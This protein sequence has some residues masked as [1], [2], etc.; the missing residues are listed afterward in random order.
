MPSNYVCKTC[1]EEFSRVQGLKTHER[2]ERDSSEDTDLHA[3]STNSSEAVKNRGPDSPRATH[4]HIS[5][6]DRDTQSLYNEISDSLDSDDD[7]EPEPRIFPLHLASMIKTDNPDLSNVGRDG[8]ETRQFIWNQSRNSRGQFEDATLSPSNGR[9]RDS[10]ENPSNL[11]SCT[12]D[13]DIGNQDIPLPEKWC[14]TGESGTTNFVFESPRLIPERRESQLCLLNNEDEEAE[15]S[16]VDED[17]SVVINDSENVNAGRAEQVDTAEDESTKMDENES[18]EDENQAEDT[19]EDE[20]IV[21]GHD[22]KFQTKEYEVHGVDNEDAVKSQDNEGIEDDICET[23][24]ADNGENGGVAGKEATEAKK[25]NFDE[26]IGKAN[27]ETENSDNEILEEWLNYCAAH[28]YET[29]EVER[30]E[31]IELD[32]NRYGQ[33]RIEGDVIF[34]ESGGGCGDKTNAVEND[35]SIEATSKGATEVENQKGVD[36]DSNKILEDSGLTFDVFFNTPVEAESGDII[37][38]DGEGELRVT[39]I[40]KKEVAVDEEIVAQDSEIT[41]AE[42]EEIIEAD[43]DGCFQ[44]R[45]ADNDITMVD[46]VEGFSGH[47]TAVLEQ[48]DSFEVDEKGNFQWGEVVVE[49]EKNLEDEYNEYLRVRNIEENET[50]IDETVKQYLEMTVK[51]ENDDSNE[52]DDKMN[53]QECEVVEKGVDG[54]LIITAER[55]KYGPESEFEQEVVDLNESMEIDSGNIAK[56]ENGDSK[57]NTQDEEFHNDQTSVMDNDRGIDADY[58]NNSLEREVERDTMSENIGVNND[59]IAEAENGEIILAADKPIKKQEEHQNSET[60]RS[61][62]EFKAPFSVRLEYKNPVQNLEMNVCPLD[63]S[64]GIY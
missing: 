55:P 64:R 41:G 34:E 60:N 36:V 7:E 46:F 17:H 29:A 3:D 37:Q 21:A 26:V 11:S 16:E 50:T 24:G 40:R 49:K 42:D 38:L 28:I 31:T 53:C 33:A 57:M 61:S 6:A 35:D 4:D 9:I 14:L 47:D 25:G 59:E 20:S 10:S 23:S 12:D 18:I 43:I 48:Y 56:V 54:S 15:E 39:E 62:V 2:N 13:I 45:G 22:D 1:K 52:V 51:V 32:D 5:L 63:L 19:D 58:F 44:V 30:D 27:S 8:H